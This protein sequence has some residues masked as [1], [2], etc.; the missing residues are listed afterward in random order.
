MDSELDALNTQ[1]R[2]VHE[3]GSYKN[4]DHNSTELARIKSSLDYALDSLTV[5]LMCQSL[6]IQ[7]VLTVALIDSLCRHLAQITGQI[8]SDR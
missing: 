8:C 7:K 5:R 4:M 1:L 6:G 3:Q 2:R